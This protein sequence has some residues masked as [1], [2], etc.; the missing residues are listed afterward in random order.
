MF[1][2]PVFWTT[3]ENHCKY[4][5]TP[6]DLPVL[7]QRKIASAFPTTESIYTM[8]HNFV[9]LHV[10]PPRTESLECIPATQELVKSLI[11]ALAR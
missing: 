6:A 5:G 1:I 11:L 8:C 10:N 9:Y 4:V 3:Q 7:G 2:R